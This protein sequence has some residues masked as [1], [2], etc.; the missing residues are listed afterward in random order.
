MK[1]YQISEEVL[2]A[3]LN[4]LGTQ[5]FQKVN[6]LIKAIQKEAAAEEI[7]PKK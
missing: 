7:K 6:G 4:Y 2:N 3:T 5:P 1:K